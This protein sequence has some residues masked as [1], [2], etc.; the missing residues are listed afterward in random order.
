MDKYTV[1]LSPS[2][3]MPKLHSRNSVRENSLRHQITTEISGR[4]PSSYYHG[5][6]RLLLGSY[7]E[8]KAFPHRY[9]IGH[10]CCPTHL[11]LIANVGHDLPQVSPT[12]EGISGLEF[13]NKGIYL[14][15]V[16]R[17]GCLTVHDF[18]ALRCM[19]YG[20]S[21]RELEDEEKQLFH[22]STMQQLEVVRW[23]A[24]NQDE[25]ACASRQNNKLPIFDIGYLS[26]EPTEVLEKGR[27]KFSPQESNTQG[28]LCDVAFLKSDKFRL[29][30][31]DT[32]GCIHMWDRR[33]G[34]F[35]CLELATNLRFSVNSI[36][37]DI[38][39]RILFGASSNGVIYSWDLR[40]GRSS[41]AFQSHNQVHHPILASLK[42]AMMLEKITSLKAQ[43]N[44]LPREIY[45]IKFNPSCPHQLAFHLSDGWSG[46]VDANSLNVTHMHCPPSA[47]LDWTDMT[48][49]YLDVKKPS[50]LPFSSIGG[51]HGEQRLLFNG[52]GAYLADS[53]MGQ[54][55]PVSHG[56]LFMQFQPTQEMEFICW[57]FSQTR[58]QD[59][60]SI[61]KP[62]RVCAAH[63][64]CGTVI[65]GTK[66]S[67]LLLVGQ[68]IG[69]D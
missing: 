31:S 16:T 52:G 69:S 41:F 19:T 60:M 4:F 43:T 15:S 39:D 36:E 5:V 62:V 45:V 9:H 7:V 26:S 27:S 56:I 40:G 10:E 37:I 8:M 66:K 30:A 51:V 50:W 38:E 34:S 32:G 2:E 63:P 20:L 64:L 11:A 3:E 29:V 65:A 48:S 54:A 46:V 58:D 35:P 44:I 59:V 21:E 18:D 49:H 55:N 67:S 25:V 13:D 12:R 42:V 47:W 17:S 68:S 24:L 57:T 14:A 61:S 6:S 23:N 33:L 53:Q 1:P 28:G 22:I